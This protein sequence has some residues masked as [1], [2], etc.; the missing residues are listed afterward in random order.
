VVAPDEDVQARTL[1][2]DRDLVATA[3]VRTTD[4]TQV[5][6]VT[7]SPAASRTARIIEEAPERVVVEAHTAAPALLVLADNYDPNWVA[8]LDGRGVPLLRVDYTF[9]GVPLPAG[10][11]RIELEYRPASVRRGALVSLLALGV[12]L[13][14][15]RAVRRP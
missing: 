2:P 8:T 7:P 6:D 5:A 15:L 12:T 1:D 14:F 4:A 9:R 13:L 3:V 10:T 11:H